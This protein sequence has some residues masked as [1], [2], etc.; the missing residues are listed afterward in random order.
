[1]LDIALSLLSQ[2]ELAETFLT[3]KQFRDYTLVVRLRFSQRF[4]MNG[5]ENTVSFT[6]LKK[7]T[8]GHQKSP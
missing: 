3:S 6:S 8:A 5:Q 1:M 4:W 2:G 7:R